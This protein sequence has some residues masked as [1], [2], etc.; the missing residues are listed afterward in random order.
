MNGYVLASPRP[1][2]G[3]VWSTC[4]IPFPSSPE[5]FPFGR[6]TG[7]TDDVVWWRRLLSATLSGRSAGQGRRLPRAVRGAPSQNTTET[8][9]MAKVLVTGASG[10]VGWHLIEALLA[11]GDEVT[12]LV[13][14]TSRVGRLRPLGVALVQGDVA[15]PQSLDRAVVGADEVYHLAGCLRTLH[16]REYYE[17]NQQGM[18]NVARAC[19]QEAKPPVLVITSSLAAAGPS[20]DGRPLTEG[21]ADRPISHYGRSKLAGEMAAGQYADRVPI[22]IVRASGVFG[23]ADPGCLE[24]FRPIARTW[25]HLAPV[26]PTL[27]VSFIYVKDLVHLM[28]LAAG[29]GSRLPAPAAETAG[30]GQGIYFAA[31]DERPDYGELGRMMSRSLGRRRVLVLPTPS[32]VVWAVAAVN[33]LLGQIIRRPLKFNLDKAREATAGCWLCSSQKAVEE[34]GF[35]IEV[36]MAD[37]LRQTAQWYR[38]EGWL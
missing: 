28:I 36:P 20:P 6:A 27:T 18:A 24:M 9:V 35:S 4:R 25:T 32:H 8:R 26:W 7:V 11:R 34:L 29:R 17:V 15:D 38:D 3:D 23:E 19:S 5:S 22:T 30:P 2:S 37:R 12:A 31:S 13:R 14:K 1:Q 16:P 21:C 10:F 33:E